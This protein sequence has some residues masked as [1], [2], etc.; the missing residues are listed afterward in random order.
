MHT[1]LPT[2]CLSYNTYQKVNCH[3]LLFRLY[4]VF[5]LN[6]YFIFLRQGWPHC[7]VLVRLEPPLQTRPASNAQGSACL[8]LT[9]A[10][11][12]GLRHQV[13]CV[14]QIV[15]SHGCGAHRYCWPA[16]QDSVPNIHQAVQF[17][18]ESSFGDTMPS[19]SLCRCQKCTWYKY[20]HGGK[21]IYTL[22]NLK[23]F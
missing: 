8:R 20:I 19:S 10:G 18:C 9:S 22:E 14:S 12:Q 13:Q 4:F 5:E 21:A 15:Q 7:V 2:A 17:L 6:F 11:I 23:C 1:L 3:T 16:I